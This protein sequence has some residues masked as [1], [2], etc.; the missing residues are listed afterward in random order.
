[1]CLNPVSCFLFLNIGIIFLHVL[2]QSQGYDNAYSHDTGLKIPI[3][4]SD[5]TSELR[6]CILSSSLNFSTVCVCVCH[7]CAGADGGQTVL[8][9]QKL[10]LQVSGSCPIGG[11]LELNLVL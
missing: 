11:Y 5:L 2:F 9:P 6:T 8:D 3:S 10:E 7:A 4:N 1:M